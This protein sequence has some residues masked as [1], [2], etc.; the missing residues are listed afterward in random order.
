MSERTRIRN[1]IIITAVAGIVLAAG[2]G[3]ISA[4]IAH[5]NGV[6]EGRQERLDETHGDL[7]ELGGAI[8]EKTEVLTRLN[9]LNEKVPSEA[10]AENIAE[11]ISGLEGVIATVGTA[12]VKTSLEGYLEAWKSFGETYT[13]ENNSAIAEALNGL[14]SKASD[15]AIAITEIYNKKITAA[16]EKLPE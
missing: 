7:T 1:D 2:I 12:E 15:T 8:K 11:Y 3:V 6:A 9:E 5:G 14:R 13:S 4:T 10:N 16:A